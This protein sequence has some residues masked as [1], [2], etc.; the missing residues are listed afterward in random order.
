MRKQR[1]NLTVT[2][3]NSAMIA[4][5]DDHMTLLCRNCSYASY[6]GEGVDG[7]QNNQLLSGKVIVFFK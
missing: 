3:R 2:A 5:N 1:K 6:S 7:K 4:S